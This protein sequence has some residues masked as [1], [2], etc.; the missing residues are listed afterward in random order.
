MCD[1]GG[2]KKEIRKGTRNTTV[3]VLFVS[4]VYSNFR[5][6]T[7]VKS[8]IEKEKYYAS[9]ANHRYLIRY[10]IKVDIERRFEKVQGMNRYLFTWFLLC[11]WR[12]TNE[13][14]FNTG[15]GRMDPIGRSRYIT[16]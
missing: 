8:V 3:P 6:R 9:I 11:L 16:A 12:I 4:I 2:Y 7:P 15:L 10:V 1:K 5:A 14:S 13:N